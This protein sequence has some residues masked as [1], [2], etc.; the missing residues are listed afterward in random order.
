VSEEIEYNKEKSR[1]KKEEIDDYIRIRLFEK[2]IMYTI[3]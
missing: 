2:S 3:E 1:H